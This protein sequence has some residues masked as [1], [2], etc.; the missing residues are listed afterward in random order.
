[1]RNY[2]EPTCRNLLKRPLVMGVPVLGLIALGAIVGV[3]ETIGGQNKIKDLVAIASAFLGYVG[4]RICVQFCKTG[5]EQNILF[6]FERIPAFVLKTELNAEIS[7]T[8]SSIEIHPPDTFEPAELASKKFDLENLIRLI[9]PGETTRYLFDSSSRGMRAFEI[10]TSKT[11]LSWKA[12][13]SKILPSLPSNCFVYSLFELPSATDPLWMFSQISTIKTAFQVIVSLKGLN[14]FK[15][16]KQLEGA[17]L[18]NSISHSV[19]AEIGFSEA[20]R[21]LEGIVRGDDGVIEVSL[22]I[23]SNEPLP[24]LDPSYFCLET[25]N[26]LALA[27]SLGLRTSLHRAHI[28]RFTTAGDLM[29][30]L[31]DPDEEGSAILQ[32]RR[33]AP[34]YFDPQDPSLM[35]LHWIV[36]GSTGSGKSLL[37]GVIL[38]RLIQDKRPISVLFV[39]HGNSFKRV[40]KN[41]GGEYTTPCSFSELEA[42]TSGALSRLNRTGSMVG[43]DLASI[44]PFDKSKSIGFLLSEIDQFLKRRKT[45]HIIYIVLDEA[46]NYIAAQP[47]LVAGAFAE[48]R[49][50]N[51]GVIAIT[52]SASDFLAEQVGQIIFQNSFIKILMKQ[53]EDITEN[54]RRLSLNLTELERAQELRQKKGLYS[55]FI[56]KISE[57][58]RLARLHPTPEEY[59]LFRTDNLR[60]EIA[61]QYQLEAA[62]A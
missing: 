62:N 59:A 2:R 35:A 16:K 53:G 36:S 49:K 26:Y 9:K 4:L 1:M 25:N 40:V 10:S 23:V 29:P 32:S 47:A 55:E 27:S 41:D 6:F 24:E 38:R 12:P 58:S 8:P 15:I 20:S 3:I 61:L 60:E 22:I 14:R 13:P 46:R 28:V 57:K 31:F 30:T 50:Y 52:Q 18:R 39:D 43:I 48:Y 5:F 17:R 19:D 37:T 45:H 44:H 42:I 56:L 11:E 54:R 34:C 33:G 21:V 51:A 7:L